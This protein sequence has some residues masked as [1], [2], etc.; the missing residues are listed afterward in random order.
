VT[1]VDVV[2]SGVVGEVLFE[3]S[4]KTSFGPTSRCISVGVG[5]RDGKLGTWLVAVGTSI[6][7]VSMLDLSTHVNKVV[8]VGSDGSR[9]RFGVGR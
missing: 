5:L 8:V 9:T 1:G 3:V 6:M 7:L 2:G 4:C